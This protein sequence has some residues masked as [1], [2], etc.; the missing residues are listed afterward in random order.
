VDEAGV[1]VAAIKALN[2]KVEEKAAE[3]RQLKQSV[4]ELKEAIGKLTARPDAS[5]H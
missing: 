2:Q 3:I 5:G 4:A 1:A